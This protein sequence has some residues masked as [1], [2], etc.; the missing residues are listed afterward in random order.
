MQQVVRPKVIIGNWKMNK[1][2]AEARS[3]V[4]G[5]A[6]A[7]SQ[8]PH[9][10][11]VAVPFTAICA[12]AEAAR[13]TPIWIGAQNVSDFEEGPYTGEIS[14]SM[15][16]D[17][18]ASFAIVGHSERRHIFHEDNALVNRKVACVLKAGLKP[19]V[20]VG[21]TL[22]QHQT[23][24]TNEVLHTQILNSLKGLSPSNVEHLILAYEPVWAIGTGK[25]ATPENVQSS[26]AHCRKVIASEWGKDTAEHIVIQ[27][28][29]SVKPDN[30]AALLALPDVDGLLVGG[31]SLSLE[32]FNQIIHALRMKN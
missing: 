23:G 16:K 13:G 9:Q 12:A 7:V 28:G 2:T 26:H 31:A 14:V 30:A 1:L 6:L 21:E 27:Y 22:E 17:A 11:G 32:S 8:I 24:K 3:Y 15:L 5:L 19:V 20:C 10:I 18:G 4:S 25:T 29:G